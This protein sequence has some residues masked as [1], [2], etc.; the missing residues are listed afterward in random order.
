MGYLWYGSSKSIWRTLGKAEEL[1]QVWNSGTC[2]LFRGFLSKSSPPL[3]IDVMNASAITSFQHI[4][5]S[6]SNKRRWMPV[7]SHMDID[8][9]VERVR[10]QHAA[11]VSW[12]S[13][14]TSA[15]S[16]GSETKINQWWRGHGFVKLWNHIPVWKEGTYGSTPVAWWTAVDESFSAEGKDMFSNRG[17]K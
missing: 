14:V 3:R 2:W 1:A 10:I 11:V 13:Y 8:I 9:S 5:R 12:A 6:E 15:A 17:G 16:V 7:G 4:W